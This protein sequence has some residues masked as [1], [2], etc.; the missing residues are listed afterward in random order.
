MSERSSRRD[1]WL[2]LACAAAVVGGAGACKK[3][4][5]PKKPEAD[6]AEVTKLAAKMLRN[7][8]TPA[9]ARECTD[10]DFEGGMTLTWRT[11]TLLGGSKPPARPE[12][13]DWINPAA[14]DAP[15]ART[16][17]E[18][19]SD[20]LARQA[21]A[22][23]LSAPFWVV[24]KVDYVNAPMALGVKELKRG[25]VGTRIIRYEKSGVPGCV[26][27][28]FF[29]NDEKISDDAIA[30]SDKAAIDPAVAKILRDDLVEQ[31]IKLAPRPKAPPAAKQ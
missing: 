13:E 7:V 27:V 21:A 16:L 6:P 22:E 23:L 20:T 24:Y 5:A 18:P 26:L 12:D 11:L 8:P 3:K 15:A 25:T 14:L 17:L 28:W 10:A 29:Q 9:A 30:V 19:P 1:A 2:A 4:S 31:F